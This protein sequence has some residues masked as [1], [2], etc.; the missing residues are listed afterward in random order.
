MVN[1]LQAVR[2]IGVSKMFPDANDVTEG[3]KREK[4]EE[5]VAVAKPRG[6]R[7]SWSTVNQITSKPTRRGV[8]GESTE[9]DSLSILQD[10]AG[11]MLWEECHVLH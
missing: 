3:R 10:T 2:E 6:P 1:S 5:S 11:P 4:A 8:M 9:F 7:R